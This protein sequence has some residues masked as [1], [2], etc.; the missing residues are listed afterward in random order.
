MVAVVA[1]YSVAPTTELGT[2]LPAVIKTGGQVNLNDRLALFPQVTKGG[3]GLRVN[4][5][6]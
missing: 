4:L 5:N 6:F 1:A 3:Y 2:R